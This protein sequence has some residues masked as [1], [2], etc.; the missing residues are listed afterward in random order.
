MSYILAYA[1]SFIRAEKLLFNYIATKK[2]T[3]LW[4]SSVEAIIALAYIR[5]RTGAKFRLQKGFKIVNDHSHPIKLWDYQFDIQ[6]IKRSVLGGNSMDLLNFKTPLFYVDRI[7]K[8]LRPENRLILVKLA[9]ESV[10]SLL[11]TYQKDIMACEA[12]RSMGII[13]EGYM[14]NKDVEQ[15][16]PFLYINEDY[17]DSPLTKKD[18]DIWIENIDILNRICNQFRLA[19]NE[20]CEGKKPDEHL[21]EISEL[22]ETIRQKL[23]DYLLEIPTGRS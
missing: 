11:D 13:L 4:I 14:N 19:Y 2:D 23:T 10:N 9:Y 22:R 15:F 1:N 17:L 3:R 5:F 18:F 16:K 20:L 7:L 8:N 21:N 12:L 6:G